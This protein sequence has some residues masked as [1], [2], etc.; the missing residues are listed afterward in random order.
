MA[1]SERFRT[2][3]KLSYLK[4]YELAH[5]AGMHPS[6]LSRILNG[7]DLVKPGDQRVAKVAGVLGIPIEECFD[8]VPNG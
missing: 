1:I 7:I 2:A 4:S 5:L 8:E 6:V 3:V